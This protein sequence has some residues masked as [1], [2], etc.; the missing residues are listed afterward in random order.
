[1]TFSS[2][3]KDDSTYLKK[4]TELIYA[5]SNGPKSECLCV[6]EVMN[7][8]LFS[9]H[10]VPDDILFICLHTIQALIPH[11]H[12][13]L[14]NSGAIVDLIYF[15]KKS[16]EI[17]NLALI[18]I[19]QFCE[20]ALSRYEQFAICDGIPFLLQII[21]EEENLELSL[22]ILC[23]LPGI[24]NGTRRKMREAK[25]LKLLVKHLNDDRV[26]EALG[27]WIKYDPL[28]EEEVLEAENLDAI[29]DR[30]SQETRL[31][32]WEGVLESSD[33]IRKNL[34]EAVKKKGGNPR[35]LEL[36][37]QEMIRYE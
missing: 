18:C 35:V 3:I 24:S 5:Y 23:A 26:V 12:N 14:E 27:K 9:I 34:Y 10:D 28:L 32:K 29:A 20:L 31:I 33:H 30:I 37:K 1:M 7:L 2:F 17:Q 4:I 19:I 15:L 36:I 8:Y 16:P 25:S 22:E 21:E 13:A 6:P 11:H